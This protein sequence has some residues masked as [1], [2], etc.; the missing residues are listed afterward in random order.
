MALVGWKKE[1]ETGIESV[2]EE[3][4]ELLALINETTAKLRADLHTVENIE[5]YL[6]EI[7]AKISAHFALEE[8]FMR[9]ASYSHLKPHK[10]DHERLLD[11]LRRIMVNYR[12][13]SYLQFEQSLTQHLNDWFMIHFTTHDSLLHGELGD[14]P[15]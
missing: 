10:D 15:H 2:D 5:S 14:H 1:Y 7:H 12:S 3:H 9:D 13:G 4:K 6:G 8:R 11:D